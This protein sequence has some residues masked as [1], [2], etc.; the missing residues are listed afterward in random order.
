MIAMK[1]MSKTTSLVFNSFSSIV[2]CSFPETRL[3]RSMATVTTT[4]RAM[5]MATSRDGIERAIISAAFIC[6]AKTQKRPL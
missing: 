6:L 1:T 4:S 3:V 2:D 5:G